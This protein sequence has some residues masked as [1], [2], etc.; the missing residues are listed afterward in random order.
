M[1]TIEERNAKEIEEVNFRINSRVDKKPFKS[2]DCFFLPFPIDNGL[3]GMNSEKKLRNV[4]QIDFNELRNDFRNGINELY[5]TMKKKY[6]SQNYFYSSII[7]F[8]FLKMHR[9]RS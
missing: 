5:E 7:S 6:L 2:M 9:G 4:D 3:K 8:G 1:E